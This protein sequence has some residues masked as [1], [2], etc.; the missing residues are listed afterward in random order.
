M[1][2]HK[3]TVFVIPGHMNEGIKQGM[4]DIKNGDFYTMNDFEKKYEKP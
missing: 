4:E 2:Y 1:I 3:D